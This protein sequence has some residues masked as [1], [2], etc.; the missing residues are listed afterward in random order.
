MVT[1]VSHVTPNRV[2][3]VSPVPRLCVKS[4]LSFLYVTQWSEASWPNPHALLTCNTHST[5]CETCRCIGVILFLVVGGVIA[6]IVLKVI[7]PRA[8]A[9]ASVLPPFGLVDPSVSPPPSPP[10]LPP[11]PSP[12]PP[13]TGSRRL[14]A[15]LLLT[16]HRLDLEGF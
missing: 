6:I 14:L 13:G 8:A 1:R 9:I 7:K 2:P 15:H 4:C 3:T 10:A 5:L 11:Y 12:P 16:L